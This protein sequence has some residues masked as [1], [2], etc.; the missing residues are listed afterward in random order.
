[1]LTNVLLYLVLL[2]IG[3]L[4]S[5]KGFIHEKLIRKAGS[6]QLFFLYILI[7]IMGLRIG[8]DREILNAIYSIG[9]KAGIYALATIIFSAFMVFLVSKYIIKSHP[10]GEVENDG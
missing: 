6:L 4:L 10:K 9:V 5:Y 8:L 7:F 2:I 3:G 1:M